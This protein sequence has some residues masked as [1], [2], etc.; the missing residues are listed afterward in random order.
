MPI[1][2]TVWNEYRHEQKD[3][4]IAKVYPKGIHGAIADFLRQDGE[5]EVATGTLDAP[6]NGLPDSLLD[7]T[8]VLIWWGH[9][10]H[11]DVPDELARKVQQAV[12]RGMGLIVL[13]S[14]HLS[15]PFRLLMG[16]SCTLKW[17]DDDRERL[18]CVNPAHPIAAG[19]P[20]HFE[21]P[22]QEMYGEPFDIPEPDETVFL[23]W[24]AGGEVF[25]SGVTWR[26]GYGKVFYFQPGHESCPTFYDANIRRVI[27]NAVHWAAPTVRR[28]KIDCPHVRPLETPA[29]G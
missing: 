22:V 17:R 28:K 16:T 10:A 5:L 8:D 3:E 14:G 19:L 9:M 4:A 25:R 1:R 29:G 15:K 13:H 26:R 24:F 27:Q 18:W 2:V 12:L 20:E 21:L 7:S 23:G 6:A 11:E